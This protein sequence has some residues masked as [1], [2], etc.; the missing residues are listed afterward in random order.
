MAQE[1]DV[2][3]QTLLDGLDSKHSD[4]K[5]NADNHLAILMDGAENWDW[6]D[7]EADFLTPKKKFTSP[8]KVCP[9]FCIH[10]PSHCGQRSPRKRQRSPVKSPVTP[11]RACSMPSGSVQKHDLNLS[12]L[13]EGAETWNWQD[14]ESDFLS[15]VRKRDTLK[16]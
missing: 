8:S 2:F 11:R 3:M 6:T 7:M 1:E 15:P 13:L 16:V 9:L 4:K 5:N 12:A 10:A 14:M